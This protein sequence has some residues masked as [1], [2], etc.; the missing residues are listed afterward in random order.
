IG[1]EDENT[2]HIATRPSLAFHGNLQFAIKEAKTLI[3]AGSHIAFFAPTAGELERIADVF[4]EYGVP[5]QIDLG[6]RV[7]QEHLRERAQPASAAA[8]LIR[9][10][11]AHGTVFS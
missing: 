7:V 2:F 9:G 1:E 8:A 11:I 4:T 10:E 5:Y 6:G 3:E